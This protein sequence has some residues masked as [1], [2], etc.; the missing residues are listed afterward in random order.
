MH[1]LGLK[2]KQIESNWNREQKTP[3]TLSVEES[4][5]VEMSTVLKIR[6]VAHSLVYISMIEECIMC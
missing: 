4:Y 2:L 5:A 1:C 3:R 6:S